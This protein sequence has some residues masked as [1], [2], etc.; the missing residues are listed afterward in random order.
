MLAPVNPTSLW[1]SSSVAD[2]R[3]RIQWSPLGALVTFLSYGLYDTFFLECFIMESLTLAGRTFHKGGTQR[4]K[5]IHYY[6]NKL[7][8]TATVS[9]REDPCHAGSVPGVGTLPHC[10]FQAL[11]DLAGMGF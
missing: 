4:I 6:T 11:P 2:E 9:T 10:P 3:D 8:S 5:C 7:M 1:H